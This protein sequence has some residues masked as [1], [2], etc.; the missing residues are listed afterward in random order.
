MAGPAAARLA[1]S[2]ATGN[3]IPADIAALGVTAK[4][5]S[6]GR[7]CVAAETA[8]PVVGNLDALA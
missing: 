3:A 8:Q 7:N 4:N 2:L 1:A 5:V 6:P